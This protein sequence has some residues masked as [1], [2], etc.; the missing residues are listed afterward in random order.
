[1]FNL[2]S[3]LLKGFDIG[4]VV[5]GKDMVEDLFFCFEV[6][7]CTRVFSTTA[8]T[9]INHLHDFRRR[10][11]VGFGPCQGTFCGSRVASLL[12]EYDSEYPSKNDLGKFWTERLK[13]SI[14]T[15]W[16]QQA[17]QLV[18]SD[19]IYRETLGIRLDKDILPVEDC[20]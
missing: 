3:N 7:W 13:G 6:S 12:A 4:S 5:S 19:S 20:R 2:V 9:H 16:G 11:R 8:I 15:S 14:F 18:L 17:K 10:S 1:V